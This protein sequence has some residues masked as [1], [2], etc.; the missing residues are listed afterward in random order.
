M[1]NSLVFI[2]ILIA[3]VSCSEPE[4]KSEV[5]D[6]YEA[7][8]EQK[9][10]YYNVEYT[11]NNGPKHSPISS[12]YGLVGLN[13]S[14][15]SGI[16]SA[17]FGLD[18]DYLP[19]YLNTI[20]LESNCIFSI[21]SNIF[22]LGSADL[23]MDSLHSPL[24]LN[25][26]LL[27]QMEEGSVNIDRKVICDNTVKLTFDLDQRVNQLVLVWDGQLR[28]IIELEYRYGIN[29]DH[30]YSRKWSFDHLSKSDY[31]ALE[32]RYKDQNQITQ[33]PFL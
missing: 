12:I 19:N 10:F 1:N 8:V 13:R 9:H 11:L 17:Y 5:N 14:A 30:S 23:I 22:D 20:Y 4:N 26:D 7:L 27:V 33:Q 31:L 15:A 6:I 16:S 18:T 28:K 32:S 21:S 24:L 2:L 25:P 3:G 29:S